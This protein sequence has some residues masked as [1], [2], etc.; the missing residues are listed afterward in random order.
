ML[1]PAQSLKHENTAWCA[2]E[3]ILASMSS[4]LEFVILED[5]R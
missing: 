1:A 3:I 5:M 2:T 4:K